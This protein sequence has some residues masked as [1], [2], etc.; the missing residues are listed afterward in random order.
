[1]PQIVSL[2]LHSLAEILDDIL[3]V[4]RATKRES[5]ART[6][7]H[8]LRERVVQVGTGESWYLPRVVCLESF[9]PLYVAG[10]WVP[11]MVTLAG[12]F[13][14]LGRKG[15]PSHK[16]AWRNVIDA[17]PDVILLMPCGFD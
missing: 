8:T 17:N 2:N 9:E 10:H 15:E 1:M 3:R 16:V 12:G 4:G 5:V 13:D 6:L 7:T 14:V 11:E